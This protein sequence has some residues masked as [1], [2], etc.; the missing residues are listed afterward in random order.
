MEHAPENR[1]RRGFRQTLRLPRAA[2]PG[3]RL[4]GE[5]G[6][7]MRGSVPRMWLKRKEIDFLTAFRAREYKRCRVPRDLEGESSISPK[8]ADPG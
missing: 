1:A 5:T 8:V 3:L 4:G 7:E 6:A 2:L